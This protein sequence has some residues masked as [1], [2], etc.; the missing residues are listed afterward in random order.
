MVAIAVGNP[1][2]GDDLTRERSITT[3]PSL[4]QDAELCWPIHRLILSMVQPKAIVAFGSGEEKSPFAYLRRF[5]A[6]S[7]IDIIHSG[8]GN[9]FCHRFQATLDGHVLNVVIVPHLTRYSPY[10]RPDIMQWVKEGI[11]AS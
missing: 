6:P 7:K 10:K 4:D 11:S 2:R 5:L 3:H 1:S 9:F 8:Q